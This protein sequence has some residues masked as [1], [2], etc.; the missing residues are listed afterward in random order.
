[1]FTA[2]RNM[3]S[4]ALASA[5]A[6]MAA[7]ARA[8]AAEEPAEQTEA[9][10]EADA[11][12]KAA[13]E[14]D[15]ELA[16]IE[17][18]GIRSGIERAID[19]KYDETSI[20]E[21]VSSEDI[22]KLPD[23]S[24]AES[25]ARLPGL[26]AQRVQGRASTIAIR[27]LAG[28]F[29]TTL[30]NGREQA[31]IGDNRGVEF[32]QYPS[33]LL[34]SAVVYKTPDAS[35]VGQGLSGTVDLRTVRPLSF[36]E[37]TF[38]VNARM[39]KNSLGELNPG[40][41]DFGNRLSASYI[42]QFADDT[43][44]IA[45][46]YARLDS[47]GQA[48]RW[49]AWG[50]PTGTINGQADVRIIGG[51]ESWSTST[52]NVRNGLMAV[53]EYQPNDFYSTAID[54][55]HSTFDKAE[56]TRALQ[57]G[58]G[59]SGATLRPGTAVVENG[60]LISGTA[61]GVKPVIRN[62]LNEREDDLF[63]VGWN[64]KFSFA[65]NWT[66]EADFSMSKAS[67]DEMILETYAGTV[68]V[69]DTVTY[70]LDP[71]TGLPT[72][73][74]GLDYSDPNI[75]R[76]TDSG[77]WG[78]DGYVKFPEVEDELTSIRLAA[79]RSF[80][81][82]FLSG[83]EF[84]VNLSDREKSR[85][86]PESFLDLR[87]RP[88]SSQ[89]VITNPADLSF[90]GIGNVL[91]YNVGSAFASLYNLRTN[92]NQDITN[93]NWVVNEKVDTFFAQMNMETEIGSSVMMKGNLGFQH[94]R[95]DQDSD[96]FSVANGNAAG[97]TPFSGG[98]SYSDTL[99]SLNLN[100]TFPYEQVLRFGAAKQMA[101]P[102]LDQM[103]ANNNYNIDPATLRWGGGGG[104]PELEPWR[105]TALD[106]SYEKYF[107]TSGYVSV[108]AFHKDLKSYIY[109]IP[110]EYDF[111]GFDDLGL[112]P[113]SD[114]GT[115]SRPENGEGGTIRGTEIAVSIPF[116]LFSQSL[117][118][119]GIVA[120]YSDTSSSI[121]P[122][123]PGSTQPLPGLSK[124]VSNLSAYF[125]R[126][127][128]STR[129]SQR[130]RSQF[131]GEIQGFGADRALVLVEGETLLDFQAGYT[132]G[133]GMFKDASLLLQV[134]NVTDE[135]YREVFEGALTPRTFNEYGRTYLLGMTYKF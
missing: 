36:P 99:P 33:E 4:V 131:L 111:S 13:E 37:R 31:S 26:A 35:L 119:F 96:G 52:D 127:G 18:V 106:V 81:A 39:E 1:M 103:R 85:N 25:I 91:G 43:V 65:D 109:T 40:V 7:D 95:T 70:T 113:P 60:V 2:K 122:N 19:L 135:P 134:Y 41:D 93:K 9:Q 63:A 45:I 83:L 49:N 126:G 88:T 55:Y 100:F 102:R 79:N 101:R 92:F 84:G 120:N 3:L 24:I 12:A 80:D 124:Y 130:H 118:G 129:I 125:E 48:Q 105:A 89:S 53:L 71:S 115:F 75:I 30:L 62:D 32:D 78:Q 123:G 110:I 94:I 51:S 114:I 128:F 46:G 54:L 17:V 42:D 112:N 28:D 68:G 76:L 56:T 38:A 97:A 16:A 50:Y 8:Q 107:G 67:R 104:N 61:D 58:L 64:N 14:K 133:D 23:V 6:I 22:G 98:T 90:T 34:S 87:T 117:E 69:T 59:W 21:A 57:V 66:A 121:E 116:D 86:V 27:G 5:I 108:A 10:T 44:G 47:P 73:D 20:V 15:K 74:F 11:K 132:F 29:A 72:L 77:G 82:G